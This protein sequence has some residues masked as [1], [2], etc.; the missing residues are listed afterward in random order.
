LSSLITEGHSPTLGFLT[1]STDP[2]DGWGRYS[3]GIVNA[4]SEFSRSIVVTDIKNK[5][6]LKPGCKVIPIRFI[7]L[8]PWK[9]FRGFMKVRR[10]LANC[11]LVHGL[12]EKTIALLLFLKLTTRK[13]IYLT[14][15]GT[16]AQVRFRNP[17]IAF[18]KIS[19]YWLADGITSGSNH[20]VNAIP[21]KRL[22][23][24]VVFIPN[25]VDTASFFPAKSNIPRGFVL[26]VGALK[27]RKGPDI[28]IE[29]FAKSG[30]TSKLILVGDQSNKKFF[31]LLI[32]R[33]S[34]L[35]I[36]NNVEFRESIDDIELLDLYQNAEC[37][38][39]PARITQDS[40]EGFPMVIF[41][42]NAAGTPV[43]TTRGFGSDYAIIEEKN[44][45]LID[46]ESIEQ[47]AIALNKAHAFNYNSGMRESS[48]KIAHA[49]DWTKIRERVW[50]FYS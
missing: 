50:G 39:L 28:L 40:F 29:A 24:K 10:A 38:V 45:F 15:H 20:T 5:N 43:I 4:L 36:G 3:H 1:I 7:G 22:R 47:L 18:I 19:T 11:E 26:F 17:L 2:V 23:N 32:E 12:N 13:R 42:A 30:I 25:G 14:L 9:T 33:V 27:F 46:Q 16:Y 21:F 48:L 35:G 8:N 31:N 34:E 41:E 6:D 49:H 37:L 44:G